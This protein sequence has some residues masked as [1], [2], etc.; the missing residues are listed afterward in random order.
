MREKLCTVGMR[1]RAYDVAAQQQAGRC[2]SSYSQAKTPDFDGE[3]LCRVPD[4]F[5]K[6]GDGE[7]PTV[8]V[9]EWADISDD[10]VTG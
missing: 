5:T 4:A 6:V 10:L 7:E 3:Q 2:P 9:R 8:K 1:G